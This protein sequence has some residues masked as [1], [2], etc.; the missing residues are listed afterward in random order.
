LVDIAGWPKVP[1]M[2]KSRKE[3][4]IFISLILGSLLLPILI[5]CV[6]YLKLLC[7]KKRWFKNQVAISNEEKFAAGVNFTNTLWAGFWTK[8]AAS[9]LCEPKIHF[10]CQILVT[11]LRSHLASIL[12]FY[13]I[14]M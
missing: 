7:Y 9:V 14:E 11:F 2:S 5:S 1:V 8:F 3:V 12:I 4:L 10:F 6:I 13:M